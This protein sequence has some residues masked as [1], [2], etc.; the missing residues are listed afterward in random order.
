MSIIKVKLVKIQI[1]GWLYKIFHLRGIIFFSRC[2]ST[3]GTSYIEK[4][5]TKKLQLRSRRRI[6]TTPF[7]D[8]LVIWTNKYRVNI[9]VRDNR[10]EK[11]ILRQTDPPKKNSDSPKNSACLNG[12]V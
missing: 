3:S 12:R 9:V 4:I 1:P 6:F 5:L 10:T 8:Y 11:Q 2:R 7:I